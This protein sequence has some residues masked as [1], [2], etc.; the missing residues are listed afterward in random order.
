MDVVRTRLM[1]QRKLKNSIGSLPPHI[2][3]GTVDCFMQTFRNEGFWAFYKG[4][5]P[6]LF[7]MGPWNIIFFITYEQ[8][9]QLY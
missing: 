6:T 5:I 2:Y 1:N 8:L 9:H 4:F 3:K 7:R